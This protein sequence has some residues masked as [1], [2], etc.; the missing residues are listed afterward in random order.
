MDRD[1][2]VHL[3]RSRAWTSAGHG[4]YS[5]ATASERDAFHTITMDFGSGC[6][7]I[8]GYPKRVRIE[9]RDELGRELHAEG[10]CLNRLAFFINPN[11]FSVNCL[12]EWNFD[13][14]EAHGEDHDNWSAPAARRFFRAALGHAG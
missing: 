4:G 11:L 6:L 9:G 5:Y 13:G 8:H 2:L 12:T 7:S 10:R 1:L 3:H 14:L